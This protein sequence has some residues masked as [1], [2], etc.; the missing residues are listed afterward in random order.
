M[1]K[2][3]RQS[4]SKPIDSKKCPQKPEVI[5]IDDEP[6]FSNWLNGGNGVQLMKLF[7]AGNFLT[8]LLTMSWSHVIETINFI[9]EVVNYYMFEY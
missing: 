7:V 3:T 4:T 9:Y 6:S 2:R 5:D 8:V 1:K